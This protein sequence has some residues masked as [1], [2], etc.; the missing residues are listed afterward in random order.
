MRTYCQGKCYQKAID[1][2]RVSFPSNV[3]RLEEDWGNYLVSQQQLDS[4]IQHFIE[5][6]YFLLN[7][8]IDILYRFFIIFD[9]ILFY[10]LKI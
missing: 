6:G 7:L 1:L 4:A 3:L 10:I 5:A 9:I 2:A 8:D